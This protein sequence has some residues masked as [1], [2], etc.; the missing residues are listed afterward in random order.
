MVNAFTYGPP[1]SSRVVLVTG[2]SGLVGTWLRRTVPADVELVPLVH[3][4]S[5]PGSASVTADLR[6][7]QSVSAVFVSVRPS[8]VIHAAMAVNAASIVAAT[9]NVT[10]GASLVGADVVY[11]STDAVF[12]GDGRP[13][14]ESAEPHPIWDYGRWKA[15]AEKVVLSGPV[16]SA[17][18]RL[19]LVVSLDPEDRAVARIRTGATRRQPTAWFHDEIRQPAM[20]SDIAEGLW[21]VASLEPDRRSGTW[22]LP[23]SESLSRYQIARRV[24]DALKLDPTSVVSAP[25]P[26]DGTRPLHINMRSDRANEEIGWEPARILN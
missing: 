2:A 22:Q 13:R 16:R 10:E 19:P 9:T 20:A 14:D 25:A 24:T 1:V 18:V 11:V 3:H 17:V 4:A 26:R 5:V 21:Q 6:D 23:G 12:S 8:L 15:Q 7:A